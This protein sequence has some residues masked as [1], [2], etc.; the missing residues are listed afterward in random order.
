MR[1]IISQKGARNQLKV[2]TRGAIAGVRG[3]D[4]FIS[5]APEEIK[6]TVLR[7]KVS[8]KKK[9][10]SKEA[11]IE[12]G[13][14]AKVQLNP[15]AS[16]SAATPD[17]ATTPIILEASKE[18]LLE[19]QESTKINVKDMAVKLDKNTQRQIEVLEKKAIES[20]IEDIKVNSPSAAAKLLTQKDL[21]MEKLNSEVVFEVFKA[22]PKIK[23][24]QKLKRDELEFSD[25]EIYKKHF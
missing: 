21:T 25:E 24:D 18:E 14:L 8:I 7:G 10:Q 23:K 4:F 12:K 6:L 5:A 11:L 22:A 19:L 2:Q 3:T 13:M 15:T 9:N 20:V 1:S 16:K 17:E